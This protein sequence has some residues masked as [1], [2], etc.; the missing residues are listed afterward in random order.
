[1]RFRTGWRE[2]FL[3]TREFHS[4]YNPWSELHHLIFAEQ[5]WHGR[6]HSTRDSNPVRY[7]ATVNDYTNRNAG[8][9]Q[10]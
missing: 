8:Y 9:K 5:F 4:L 10:L 3:A 7:T 2:G 1:M 6:Y